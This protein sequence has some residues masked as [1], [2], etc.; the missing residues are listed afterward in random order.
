MR[1]VVKWE[2][3]PGAAASPVVQ[4]EEGWGPVEEVYMEVE[5]W[6]AASPVVHKEEGWAPVEE[7]YMEVEPW[8]ADK[9]VVHKEEA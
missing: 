8:A 5:L 2:E 4:Q 1:V 9:P 7:V 6:A 3:V